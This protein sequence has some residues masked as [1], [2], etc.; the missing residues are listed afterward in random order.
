MQKYHCLIILW[1]GIPTAQVTQSSFDSHD[2]QP[3][4]YCAL[5]KCMY[6]I[7]KLG[8]PLLCAVSLSGGLYDFYC[9]FVLVRVIVFKTEVFIIPRQSSVCNCALYASVS[10]TAYQKT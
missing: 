8:K 6:V 9:Y 7:I 5:Y 10:G 3:V 4:L 2:G 1:S